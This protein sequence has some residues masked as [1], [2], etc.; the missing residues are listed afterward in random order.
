[1]ANDIWYAIYDTINSQYIALEYGKE[2]IKQKLKDIVIATKRE[3]L[4]V[5]EMDWDDYE[6]IKNSGRFW[7]VMT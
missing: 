3:Y 5:V 1:M 6:Q 7:G 2:H 4:I